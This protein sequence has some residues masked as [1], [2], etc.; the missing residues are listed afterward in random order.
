MDA[1]VVGSLNLDTTLR[2]PRLPVAGETVLGVGRFTDTGGKGANQAVALARL[3]RRVA[4]VGMVGDDEAGGALVAALTE[5]GVDVTGV[6]VSPDHR[7]GMAVI[8]VE[9]SGE[10]AIVV[11]PGANGALDADR[12]EACADVLAAAAVT[13]IQL[14]V[15]LEAVA[16]AVFASGGR[17]VL[18]PAPAS[19]LPA[20]VLAGVS[21]LVPNATELAL[22]TGEAV[23]DDPAA[24]ARLAT[25][26][27]GP[28]AVVVTLGPRGAVVVGPEGW[29]HLP[30]PRVE[31]V[32]PTAAGDAFCGG[33][34]D[35]LIDGA[36]LEEAAGWA[37][38][39]G[40]VSV[41]RWGAQASLPTRAEV[42]RLEPR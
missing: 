20:E 29:I 9:E 17:V 36:S 35:A 25:Q 41:S 16:A 33:L 6:T 7:T 27:A 34:A 3:G 38:R 37:V 21:V 32:D 40:A 24:A 42:E 2:V 15:P 31:V 18:N 1:V 5:A 26:V 39:C 12:V 13:L 23:P 4:M 11:D 30:A 19:P 14:E 22:L 10:N 8:T 28:E